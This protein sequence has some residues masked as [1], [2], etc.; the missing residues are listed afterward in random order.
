MLDDIEDRKC[1]EASRGRD[2]VLHESRYGKAASR[3][4]QRVPGVRPA[5]EDYYEWLFDELKPAKRSSVVCQRCH[6]SYHPDAEDCGGDASRFNYR[7]LKP[8]PAY[9]A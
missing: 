8:V 4:N 1:V 2:A 9:S 6:D 3:R 5:P 7:D